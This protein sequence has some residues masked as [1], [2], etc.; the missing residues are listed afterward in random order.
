[1]GISLVT[2]SFHAMM[3][4]WDL[5]ITTTSA[6]TS[7]AEVHTRT[8]STIWSDSEWLDVGTALLILAITAI[9]ILAISKK[10]Y[11][12]DIKAPD[13]ENGI[14]MW[15]DLIK[16]H[17]GPLVRISGMLARL[18]DD[19]L[20]SRFN[21]LLLLY[22]DSPSIQ[23]RLNEIA[24]ESAR[25]SFYYFCHLI[26]E[27]DTFHRKAYPYAL[28]SPAKNEALSKLYSAFIGSVPSGSN[29][30]AVDSYC[31][32]QSLDQE[33]DHGE[34]A[35][36]NVRD[37]SVKNFMEKVLSEK[38]LK[39][40]F[41]TYKNW[42]ADGSADLIDAT[43]VLKEFSKLLNQEL[44]L[45]YQYSIIKKLP[46]I[47]TIPKTTSYLDVIT[48]DSGAVDAVAKES[49]FPRPVS[50]VNPTSSTSG[51]VGIRRARRVDGDDLRTKTRGPRRPPPPT[52]TLSIE[53]IERLFNT[54]QR[55]RPNVH[56]ERDYVARDKTEGDIVNVQN[57]E[58][59]RG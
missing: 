38:F 11:Q 16:N 23:G 46:L 13:S 33:I 59:E 27:F 14:D 4:V 17:Y 48:A 2:Y 49:A 1:V 22:R 42:L 35:H 6:L 58:N 56:T 47:K 36:I 50:S 12:H 53:V 19:Y 15:V 28:S 54:F 21:H 43:E 31:I 10:Y 52:E 9:I 51:P 3:K 8:L 44:M 26:Y 5:I 57:D 55:S 32:V 25:D 20:L 39:N 18:L 24:E 34:S 45:F 30:G 40:E 7:L 41:K 29:M 37:L